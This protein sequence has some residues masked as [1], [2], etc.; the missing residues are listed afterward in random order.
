MHEKY[1]YVCLVTSP[2]MKFIK[3]ALHPEMNKKVREQYITHYGPDV[4]V[5]AFFCHKPKR[6]KQA[7]M[8]EFEL[9]K[10][11]GVFYD[12]IYVMTYADFLT[13]ITTNSTLGA[14]RTLEFKKKASVAWMQLRY[15]LHQTCESD[16][17]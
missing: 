2:I 13:C 17:V 8:R 10:Y 16:K 15:A 11:A 1:G 4:E 6:V 5:K 9:L 3:L 7:F 12:A 14:C